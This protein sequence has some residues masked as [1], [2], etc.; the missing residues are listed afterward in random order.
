MRVAWFSLRSTFGLSSAG[1]LEE[2]CSSSV[3]RLCG[4]LVY[5]LLEVKSEQGERAMVGNFEEQL[6]LGAMKLD[7]VKPAVFEFEGADDGAGLVEA[8]GGTTEA[9]VCAKWPVC[10]QPVLECWR[11]NLDMRFAAHDALGAVRELP[12]LKVEIA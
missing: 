3:N 5:D 8:T 11:G 1:N 9:V 2:R 10:L 4:K 7:A 12:R 6:E